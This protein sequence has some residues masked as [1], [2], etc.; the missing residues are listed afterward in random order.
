[1]ATTIQ[2]WGRCRSTLLAAAVLASAAGATRRAAASGAAPERDVYWSFPADGATDVPTNARLLAT[3]GGN[4]VPTM[5]GEPLVP[6]DDGGYDLGVLAPFTTYR[7]M[8]Q[9]LP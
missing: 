9:V 1:M 4:L 5:N 8:W 6:L 3:S 7:I 2:R